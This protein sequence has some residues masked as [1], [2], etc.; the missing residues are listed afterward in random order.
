MLPASVTM[1]LA[2]NAPDRREALSRIRVV[3]FDID[4]TLTDATTSWLG[5]ELGWTQTYSTRDGEAILELVRDGL[6]VLPLS[7]NRTTTARV[8]MESLKLRLDW[9]GTADKLASMRDL[10]VALDVPLEAV[11]FVG[12]GREDAAIFEIVGVGC[13]VRDA[14][15]AARRSAAWRLERA[16]GDRVMEEIADALLDV[17]CATGRGGS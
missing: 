12:D 15:P 3:A 14:H 16:G 4:G 17:R 10:S 5:P 2:K 6:V 1:R 13:A 7:R 9:L 11:L 8:R